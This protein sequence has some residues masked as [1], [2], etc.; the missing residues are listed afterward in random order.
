M[1]RGGCC[2]AP[3]GPCSRPHLGTELDAIR[4]HLATNEH[5]ID[6][7]DLHVWTVTSNLP[8]LSAHVVIDDGCFHD[9]V[10]AVVV[11]PRPATGS[12]IS[13]LAPVPGPS[14]W[15]SSCPWCA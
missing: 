10:K 8:A 15:P 2:A 14:L 5:V 3:G 4:D 12:V 6:V 11:A 9:E 7:H 13:N 1:P